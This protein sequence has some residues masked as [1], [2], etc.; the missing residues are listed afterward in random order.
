MIKQACKEFFNDDH[1]F[2]LNK[3]AKASPSLNDGIQVF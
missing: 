2:D 3:A 1:N